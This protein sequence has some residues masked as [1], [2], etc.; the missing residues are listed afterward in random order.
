MSNLKLVTQSVSEARRV[1]TAT[2][3]TMAANEH[4]GMVVLVRKRG[5]PVAGILSARE[6]ERYH[7]WRDQRPRNG[8]CR[9]DGEGRA[10]NETPERQPGSN[11]DEERPPPSDISHRLP[12]GWPT[13]DEYVQ[14]HLGDGHSPESVFE[15]LTAGYGDY[16][17]T[18]GDAAR[19]VL[20]V[21]GK[22]EPR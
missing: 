9:L 6:L 14:Q 10:H 8:T 3:K 20:S 18:R 7:Q 13:P 5:V 1:F 11:R 16:G 22:E 19:L 12:A 17:L 4:H 15:G 2:L 21:A